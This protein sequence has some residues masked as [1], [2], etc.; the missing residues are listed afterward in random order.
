M[1][2]LKPIDSR[3]SFYWKCHVNNYETD[4]HNIFDLV[5]Y[6]TRVASYD[7]TTKEMSVYWWHSMTTARHINA[8]LDHFGYDTV[9]KD[10]MQNRNKIE[11]EKKHAKN[12][13]L[14]AIV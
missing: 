4:W 9:D 14:S 12:V 5:S 6:T 11:L 1:F 7:A 3:K 10:T 13:V 2:E 8:F